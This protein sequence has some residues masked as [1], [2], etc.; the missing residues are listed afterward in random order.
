M[1]NGRMRLI[2]YAVVIGALTLG[3]CAAAPPPGPSV[4]AMP[5]KDKTF[6]AFQA[7]DAVCR[8]YASAQIGYTTPGEAANQS[9]VGSTVLGTVLGAAAGAAIGAA[10]GNPA[11]G[12]AIGAGSGL[13]IGGATGLN[14]AQASGSSLQGRYDIAY[15]QCMAAKGENVPTVAAASGYPAYVPYPAY[16]YYPYPGYYR[17]PGYYPYP[18]YYYRPYYGSVFFGGGFGFHHGGHHFHGG[19]RR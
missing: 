4:V 6:E 18:G 15:M 3:G 19:R 13:V 5:G 8:Q 14:A 1:Y 11:A 2:A 10:V 17:Y 7:D 16:A 9:A 12:A